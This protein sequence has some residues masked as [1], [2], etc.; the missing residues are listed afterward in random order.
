MVLGSNI[1]NDALP[2]KQDQS[3]GEKMM[4]IKPTILRDGTE[5][6]PALVVIVG[7]GPTGL[8]LA[9]LLGQKGVRSTV[10]EKDEALNE[11]P[12]AVAFSGPVHH[13]F[14]NI[15]IY[16]TMVQDAAKTPGFCWRKRAEDDGEGGRGWNK[17]GKL[18]LGKALDTNMVTVHF[19]AELYRI[20]QNED[21]VVAHVRSKHGDWETRGQYIAGCDGGQSNVRRLM[22]VKMYGHSWQ[23]RFM[24]TD[25]IRTPPVVEEVNIDYIVDPE[26]WAIST[27]LEPAKAGQRCLWRF[28]MAV[29]D[30]RIP[31]EEVTGPAFVNEMLLRHVDG[32]RPADFE[33]LRVNLYRMHQFLASTMFR[34]R[35][36]LAGDA[37]H[38]TNPIGG[39]GLCTGMLDAAALAQAFDLA[40]NRYAGD[41]KKQK[42]CF[43]AYSTSRRRV[44]QTVVHP[45]S[46]AAK[47]RLHC[48]SPDD[49][50]EE[51]WY[52]RTLRTGN[53]AAIDQLH[54]G[55]NNHWRTDIEAE[56]AA[57]KVSNS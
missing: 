19:G 50:A 12:R 4:A 23:E 17:I 31:D 28:S 2:T 54:D 7:A 57:S 9:A 6:P 21:G 27:P 38:L 53:K 32:P 22:G 40:A 3:S 49:I 36:F 14:Q 29:T 55:L 11:L 24:A 26:Y 56:M 33:V 44:F 8:L 52:M 1:S 30:D 51:D 13:I 43:K 46:S 41:A 16:D 39:L 48:G 15:G 42:E 34:G 10:L 37:A 5:H 35:C 47:T 25:I 45:T 20:D 18:L